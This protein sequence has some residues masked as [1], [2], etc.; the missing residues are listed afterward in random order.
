MLIFFYL[1]LIAINFFLFITNKKSKMVS[2]F[3]TVFIF[4]LMQGNSY[5][6]DYKN[7]EFF[8]LN[9]SFPH[10]IEKGFV[11]VS[12]WFS[13]QN[14]NYNIFLLFLFIILFILSIYILHKYIKNYNFL[15]VC[16]SSYLMFFDTVQIR[17]FIVE[18]AYL[19][20]LYFLSENK[21]MY[22]VVTIL[23]ASMFHRTILVYL[24]LYL[25][26]F[27]KK[28][29]SKSILKYLFCV[30]ILFCFIIFLN[31][32]KVPFIDDI[33]KLILDDSSQKNIYF[34]TVTR[35]GFILT[36][37]CY[38][39]NVFISKIAYDFTRKSFNSSIYNKYV[40]FSRI[41]YL[42]NL[43][44]CFTLPLL[45]LN[46]NFLRF[47]RINNLPIYIQIAITLTIIQNMPEFNDVHINITNRFFI[48]EN[49]YKFFL[50]MYI[51]IWVLLG[52]D[53]SVFYDI[54]SNNLYF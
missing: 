26:F 6:A 37:I 3:S 20:L 48:K 27:L 52:M 16:Y 39:V 50:I 46:N 43:F 54:L 29:K 30:I 23:I 40:K 17:F 33:I 10:S 53:W 34:E 13:S 1:S 36:F 51:L 7:Y 21:K 28:R 32:N 49:T 19:Y 5:N 9:Q 15:I 38:F 44:S 2:I 41:V 22:F 31:G 45:M 14:L 25:I 8:Y 11:A 4:L 42:A 35:L 18:I 47:V 12:N 24:P